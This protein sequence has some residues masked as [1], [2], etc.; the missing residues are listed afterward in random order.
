[1]T[2]KPLLVFM[3]SF[4]SAF[5]VATPALGSAP[6]HDAK[7]E[8]ATPP[9]EY[10]QKDNQLVGILSDKDATAPENPDSKTLFIDLT[11]KQS[12]VSFQRQLLL[13]AINFLLRQILARVIG[14]GIVGEFILVHYLSPSGRKPPLET[15]DTRQMITTLGHAADIG[16]AFGILTFIA[17]IA[18]GTDNL[19]RR[20]NDPISQD[21]K[22]HTKST[23]LF[24]V[25]QKDQ[26]ACRK[27]LLNRGFARVLLQPY[28]RGYESSSSE[29]PQIEQ[30]NS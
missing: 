13:E 24:L 10:F 19:G 11:K 26:K 6:S 30:S 15:G 16:T 1:M 28:L 27:A 25:K 14:N 18:Q 2:L 9:I 23:I 20:M 8:T 17:K 21:N 4:I 5:V 12:W 3:T 29:L 22:I 7:Q